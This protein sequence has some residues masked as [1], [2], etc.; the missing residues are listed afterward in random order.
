MAG[1]DIL[2]FHGVR[3]EVQNI[4]PTN[5]E[6]CKAF[7]RIALPILLQIKG[8]H[9]SHEKNNLLLSFILVG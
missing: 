5:S 3:S 1:M 6:P 4:S 9:L 8:E 2:R 7:A